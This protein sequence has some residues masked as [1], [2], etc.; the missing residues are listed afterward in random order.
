MAT[1]HFMGRYK[2]QSADVL[3]VIVERKALFSFI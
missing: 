2:A 3:P 1:L